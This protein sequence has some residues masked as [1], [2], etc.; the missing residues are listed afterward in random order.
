MSS[1]RGQNKYTIGAIAARKIIKG[2]HEKTNIDME[3]MYKGYIKLM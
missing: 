1:L 2:N 3:Q